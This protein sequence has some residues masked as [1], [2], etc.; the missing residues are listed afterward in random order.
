M[1]SPN[2]NLFVNLAHQTAAK[3][4]ELVDIK[5][6]KDDDAPLLINSASSRVAKG[7]L[8]KKLDGEPTLP[9]NMS[10]LQLLLEDEKM[11]GSIDQYLIEKEPD[12][13]PNYERYQ[14]YIK[15]RVV[16]NKII[17]TIRVRKD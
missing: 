16:L 4:K 9:I 5:N 7:L 17:T 6:I 8:R 15:P 1:Q 10:S 11:A 14:L 13:D 12:F 2:S 3:V